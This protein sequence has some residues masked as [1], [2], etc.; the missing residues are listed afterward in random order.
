MKVYHGTS[1]DCLESIL[2]N[3]LRSDQDT[4]WD[5]SESAVYFWY[6]D[7][8]EDE[9][10][11]MA[12]DQALIA[13]AKAK[14][15]RRVVFEFDIDYDELCEDDSCPGMCGA[16]CVYRDITPDEITKV[17]VENGSLEL[18]RGYLLAI[19]SDKDMYSHSLTYWER[20]VAAAF[21]N[22][23][24]CSFQECI[25]ESDFSEFS[26]EELLDKSREACII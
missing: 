23:G 11:L 7:G 10:L 12:K 6:C 4:N 19:V 9:S 14:D 24:D 18:I 25:D 15:C 17:F 22:A 8:D 20:Q 3:G 13:C 26:V 5:C 16:G 1:I 2:K 21:R